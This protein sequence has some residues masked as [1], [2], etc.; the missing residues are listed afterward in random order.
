MIID[1]HAHTVPRR[2]AGA[3]ET[4]IDWHGIRVRADPNGGLRFHVGDHSGRLPW[5]NFRQTPQERT[6]VLDGFGIDKQLLSMS[7]ALWQYRADPADALAGAREFNDD[8]AEICRAYPDRFG[9]FAWLPLQDAD[10]SVTELARAVNDLGLVGAAVATHVNGENWDSMRL[11]PVMQAAAEL[12]ALIFIHPAQVRV[13]DMIPKFHLRNIIGNPWEVTTA[14]GSL[15]FGGVI[16]RLPDLKV[17]LAHGGG[18][19]SLAMGRMDHAHEVRAEAQEFIRRPPSDYLQQFYYDTI[20]HSIAGLEFLI[21]Q[22]GA[23]RMVLGT[24]YPADMATNDPAGSVEAVAGLSDGD[25][26][27]ILGDNVAGL[28][29][30]HERD[31]A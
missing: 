21:G 20:T 23:D 2:I 7:P 28:L 29:G 15:V 13:R 12:G 27:L 17:I 19:A 18:Y 24:D 6:V 30:T 26:K 3:G 25:K 4:E 8:L 14:A 11:F 10:A 22:V 1:M 16:D 31:Q 5:K 9:G